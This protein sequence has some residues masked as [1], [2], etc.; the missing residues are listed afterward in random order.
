M[1]DA[2]VLGDLDGAADFLRAREDAHRQGRLHRLLHGRALHAAV[3]R[4]Q[5][6]PRRGRRLLG[7]LHRPRHAR[8]GHDAR[9]PAPAARSRRALH[10]PLLAAIGAEDHNPSPEIAEQ[11]RERAAAEGQEV[12]V[13]VYEGAGHAFFADYRPTYR[14]GRGQ[15]V[16][17][18]VPFLDA[19][20]ASAER[21]PSCQFAG[22][23]HMAAEP[24]GE[25]LRSRV[26]RKWWTLI[27]VSRRRSSCCCST[28]RS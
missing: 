13:D 17:R 8:R 5:R 7:R 22:E 2:T 15:A 20:S 19:T 9:A 10:C 14:P 26:E 23:T 28:S 12:K 1:S 27:A 16:A 6:S 24:S 18:V 11:L 4:L 21:A 3:R 25:A